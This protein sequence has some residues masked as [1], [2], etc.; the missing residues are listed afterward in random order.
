MS[1]VPLRPDEAPGIARRERRWWPLLAVVAV[2]LLVVFGG[3]VTAG[4]LAEPAGPPVGFPGVVSVRPLSGWELAGQANLEFGPFL[5][6]TRGNGNL[7]V[8][9]VAGGGSDE[10]AL[11]DAYVRDVL[12]QALSQ[13]SVSDHLEPITLSS[14]RIALRFSYIGVVADTHASIEGEVTVVATSAGDGV[15]FDGWTPE[16]LLTYASGDIRTMVDEAVIA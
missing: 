14:R 1:E 8:F 11:A 12:Q 5:R 7:D 9:A 10:R 4:A 16:G 13:V 3:Y 15:V 2:I 6:L